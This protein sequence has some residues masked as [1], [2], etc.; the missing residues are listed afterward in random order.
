MDL[1][2]ISKEE[3]ELLKT[4]IDSELQNKSKE[5]RYSDGFDANRIISPEECPDTKTRLVH[6]RR[7]ISHDTVARH[8]MIR[9]RKERLDEIAKQDSACLRR[10]LREKDNGRKLRR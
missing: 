9:A 10:I 1:S 7:A 8:A 4:E 2:N 6:N 3:L 5:D